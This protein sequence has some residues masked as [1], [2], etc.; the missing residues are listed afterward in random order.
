MTA[1]GTIAASSVGELQTV[2]YL[3]LVTVVIVGLALLFLGIGYAELVGFARDPAHRLM[4]SL[5]GAGLTLAL[6]FIVAV[7]GAFLYS[8]TGH[9]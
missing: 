4:S 9:G 7:S 1:L 2:F 5:I 6:L 3:V 8:V